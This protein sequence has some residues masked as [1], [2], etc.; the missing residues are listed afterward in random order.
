VL[1]DLGLEDVMS[2]PQGTLTGQVLSDPPPIDGRALGDLLEQHT[3]WAAVPAHIPREVTLAAW[4]LLI[5]DA[6]VTAW[7]AGVLHGVLGCSGRLCEVATLSGHPLLTLSLAAPSLVSLIGLACFTR[8]FQIGTAPA[9]AILAVSALVAAAAVAGAVA[10][11]L[12]ALLA[13]AILV[14]LIAL[15]LIR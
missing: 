1:I 14:L 10:L 3:P 11:V 2:E 9:L 13:I 6:A 5:C 7:L 12:V 8:A 15:L 4:S